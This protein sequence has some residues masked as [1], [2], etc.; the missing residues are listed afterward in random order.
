M[1]RGERELG[2]GL[3]Q[4]QGQRLGHACA[5]E[6][7]GCSCRMNQTRRGFTSVRFIADDELR[8]ILAKPARA[9][10][11]VL[12]KIGAFCLAEAEVGQSRWVI[13]GEIELLATSCDG[14]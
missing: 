12:P 7:V 4:E 13:G 14:S 9:S 8:S 2:L 10:T 11:S 3:R 6:R 5:S 1:T